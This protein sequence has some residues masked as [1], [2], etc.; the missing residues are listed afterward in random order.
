MSSDAIASDGALVNTEEQEPVTDTHHSTIPII[1]SPKQI[2]KIIFIPRTAYHTPRPVYLM[3]CS[4]LHMV[5]S[6]PIG[7]HANHER[8]H[9]RL[10][11]CPRWRRFCIK[12]PRC[13]PCVGLHGSN[14]GLSL[15][16]KISRFG[17]YDL[18]KIEKFSQTENEN[19]SLFLAQLLSVSI[20]PVS[21]GTGL[22]Y[23]LKANTGPSPSGQVSSPV[24]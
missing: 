7:A 13:T 19:G 5:I 9:V 21:V 1:Y 18:A 11:R 15:H 20:Q 4:R 8:N 2:N 24:E 6:F 16:H 23:R 3:G 14:C 10:C 12:W 17:R 22:Q